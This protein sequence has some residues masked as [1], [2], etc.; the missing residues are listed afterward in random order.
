MQ[1][2]FAD[3]A[4]KFFSTG[5]LVHVDFETVLP[6]PSGEA[7]KREMTVAQSHQLVMP[8]EAFLRICLTRA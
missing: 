1:T 7:E 3:A 5:S 2:H 4:I 6:A 8:L